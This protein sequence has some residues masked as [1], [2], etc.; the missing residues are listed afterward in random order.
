MKKLL[1]FLLIGGA[2]AYLFTQF[3][4][5]TT[6]LTV[7]I[8]AIRFNLKET[9]RSGF[10]KLMIDV[11]LLLKNASRIQGRVN[12]GRLDVL[13]GN[14]VVGSVENIGSMSIQAAADTTVPVR[15]GLNSLAIV[16]TISDLIKLVGSGGSQTVQIKGSIFTTFGELSVNENITFNL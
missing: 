3:K 15:V 5:F 16:P 4:Q 6:G 1:P 12:G 11:N 10:L 8:G 2:A 14:R 7:R 9:Q 13:I